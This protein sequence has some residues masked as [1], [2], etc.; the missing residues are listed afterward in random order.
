MQSPHYDQTYTDSGFW[1]KVK[2]YA[3]TAGKAVLE[4]ALQMYYA[5]QDADTPAWA[6]ATIIGA[7]GYFISP[8]DLIPDMLPVVGYSD[9]LTVLLAAIT[10]V[11]KYIKHEHKAKARAVM[12]RWFD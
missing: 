7:L 4:P 3:K 9:D 10:A 2:R 11:A 8:L 6:K 5:L 1:A 12:L